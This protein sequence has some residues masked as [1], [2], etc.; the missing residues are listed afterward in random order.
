MA[1]YL[2]TNRLL[3]TDPMID[4]FFKRLNWYKLS[5]LPKGDRLL[6]RSIVSFFSTLPSV[7]KLRRRFCFDIIHAHIACPTGFVAILLGI[8]F[9]KPV[10]VTVHGSDIHTLQKYFFLKRLILF[11]LKRVRVVIA[12]SRSLKDL[13]LKMGYFHNKAFVIHN[14]VSHDLFFPVD[15]IK[16]RKSLNLPDDR[17][18]ILFIGSLLRIKGIDTLLRSFVNMSEKNH[19]NLV[20][21]RRFGCSVQ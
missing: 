7:L 16:T 15:K 11:T 18:I 13:I 12:V 2:A 21:N 8:T 17:K 4:K 6:F 14:D 19:S 20:I 3:L 5:I 10:I 1:S 9:R